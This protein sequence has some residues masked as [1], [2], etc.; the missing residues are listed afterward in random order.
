MWVFNLALEDSIL[1][2]G[3]T[4]HECKKLFVSVKLF[5]IYQCSKIYDLCHIFEAFC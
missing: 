4:L 1:P 3:S 2:D 5:V